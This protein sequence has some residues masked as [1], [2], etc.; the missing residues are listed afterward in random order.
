MQ[1][2]LDYDL[3]LETFRGKVEELKFYRHKEFKD[4]YLTYKVSIDLTLHNDLVITRDIIEALAY[5][6]KVKEQLVENSSEYSPDYCVS[7]FHTDKYYEIDGY[8]G[9][10][11]KR[12]PVLLKDFEEVTY[13]EKEVVN[14]E[15]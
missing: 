11:E 13:V 5:Y 3:Y 15:N 7:C 12:I 4:V 8:S 9:Y 10:L 6:P 2:E 1:S 14:G